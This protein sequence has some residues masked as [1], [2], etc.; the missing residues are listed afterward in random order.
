LLGREWDASLPTLAVIGL[1]PSAADETEDDPT[2]RRC[3]GFAR[4]FGCG[5]LHMLN[6]FAFRSTDPKRLRTTL[7]PVGPENDGVLRQQLAE[8]A[9]ILAA[10]GMHGGYRG[11]DKEVR[12]L[13]GVRLNHLGHPLYLKSDTPLTPWIA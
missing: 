1:N 4:S 11:R 12:R 2:I 7:D 6:L 13:F 10:W 8:E 9:I 5:R 3:I